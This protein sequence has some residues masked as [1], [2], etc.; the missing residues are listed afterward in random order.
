[1]V[2]SGRTV[3][4]AY[5]PIH[6]E[7]LG[8]FCFLRRHSVHA[9]TGRLRLLAEIGMVIMDFHKS[10]GG[11]NSPWESFDADADARLGG[12]LNISHPSKVKLQMF[13]ILKF[14]FHLYVPIIS[15]AYSSGSLMQNRQ[16]KVGLVH[17]CPRWNAQQALGTLI[18]FFIAHSKGVA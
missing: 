13:F 11:Q 15:I 18:D 1:M 5:T 6:I 8:T 4:L 14:S 10:I 9:V 16:E 7:L 2:S 3:R 12:T 17:L